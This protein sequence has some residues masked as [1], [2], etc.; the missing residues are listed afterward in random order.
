MV[1]SRPLTIALVAG[2]TSGDILGAG[3]IRALKARVPNARFVVGAGPWKEA[4][5]CAGWCDM[6]ERAHMGY[7]AYLRSVRRQHHIRD[8]PFQRLSQL[9]PA[10]HH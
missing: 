6:E 7:V 1:D 4:E 8:G 10:L 5:R 2:E 9:T 3:L